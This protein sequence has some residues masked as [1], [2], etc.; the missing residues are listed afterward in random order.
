M[1]ISVGLG[2][3]DVFDSDR[4]RSDD[5]PGPAWLGFGEIGPIEIAFKA[6]A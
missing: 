3:S 2:G 5:L 6:W 4:V 1:I